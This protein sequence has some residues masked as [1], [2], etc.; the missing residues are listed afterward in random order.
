MLFINGNLSEVSCVVPTVPGTFFALAARTYEVGREGGTPPPWSPNIY[1]FHICQEEHLNGGA[2]W[3][4]VKNCIICVLI[5]R[6]QKECFEFWMYLN[7]KNVDEQAC[8][9]PAMEQGSESTGSVNKEKE[10]ILPAWIYLMR[11]AMQCKES[12]SEILL[13]RDIMFSAMHNWEL[14]GV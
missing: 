8:L 1:K 5:L 14:H 9:P 13:W 3:R 10:D 12:E 2:Q 6:S 4:K 7:E 11:L